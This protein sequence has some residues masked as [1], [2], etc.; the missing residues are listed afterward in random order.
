[1]S[2]KRKRMMKKSLTDTVTNNRRT[3]IKV[4]NK[5]LE[6]QSWSDLP[7]ELLELTLSRLTLADNVRAS[8][9]CKRWN[10]SASAVRVVNQ[11]PWLM[12][13]PKIGDW[14]EFYDPVHRKTYCQ[15]FAELAGSILCCAKDGWLLL[16]RLRSHRVFF[17]NPFT[18]EVIKLPTFVMTYQ[19][20][21]FS[22]AP[23]SPGCVVFTV[24]HVTHLLAAISTCHPGASEWTTVNYQ[25]RLPFVSSCWNKIVF[26]NGLFYCLS[27]A[28]ELGV[29]DPVERVWNV[30]AAPSLKCPGNCFFAK[31]WW[32]VKFM[33]EHEGG[34]VVIHTCS[35]QK[36][37]IFKLDQIEME[38]KK[39]DTLEGATV[40]ASL[41]SSLSRT[42]LPGIMTNSV[43][44]SKVRFHG[45]RCISYSLDHCRYYPC[46]Q[47]HDWGERELFENVWIEPPKN[48]SAFVGES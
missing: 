15:E 33:A 26:C 40:F 5:A 45:K 34:I 10:S 14:Y 29:F 17:F 23:T 13:F 43:Y 41:S 42:D 8:A 9:V 4:K 12:R 22:C 11:S 32:K 28:G 38:W 7:E 47:C 27:F 20:I 35:S 19:M 30:L 46:K 3:A 25:N 48:F 1:M 18:R 36:P 24:K 2:R 31:S 6:L 44:F 39:M 37:V 16:Y 21:A